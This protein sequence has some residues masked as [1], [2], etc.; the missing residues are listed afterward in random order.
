MWEKLGGSLSVV[1]AGGVLLVM[2]TKRV[3]A[4]HRAGAERDGEEAAGG[5]SAEAAKEAKPGV[6]S[7]SR[8]YFVGIAS[9]RAN[10]SPQVAAPGREG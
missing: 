9:V 10:P 5:A 2:A 3:Q 7:V 6:T 4:P 1:A 8:R